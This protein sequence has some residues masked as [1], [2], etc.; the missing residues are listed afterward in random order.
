MTWQ[1]SERRL[2][3][4][5]TTATLIAAV[6]FSSTS[7]PSASRSSETSATGKPASP[8]PPEEGEET[9]GDPDPLTILRNSCVAHTE[10][11]G[12]LCTLGGIRGIGLALLDALEASE[13]AELD[14]RF[15]K[16][17]LQVSEGV[18][19]NTL[20]AWHR[21]WWLVLPLGVLF[22]VAATTTLLLL[23]RN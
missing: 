4:R 22:G 16:S 8:L 3:R 13:K 18:C 10:P 17:Q 5:S 15:Q 7:M 23:E 2:S 21:Q 1:G 14:L 6:I 12:L 11:P 19:A 20:R 9:R